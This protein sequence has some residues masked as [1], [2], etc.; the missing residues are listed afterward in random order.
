MPLGKKLYFTKELDKNSDLCRMFR[1][2]FNFNFNV[3]SP[4]LDY[5]MVCIF[6]VKCCRHYIYIRLSVSTISHSIGTL[7]MT[8][9][10]DLYELHDTLIYTQTIEMFP[11]ICSTIVFA[12]CQRTLCG[13]KF[14]TLDQICQSFEFIKPT[15][16]DRKSTDKSISSI[17]NIWFSSLRSKAPKYASNSELPKEFQFLSTKE[18][19]DQNFEFFSLNS[20]ARIVSVFYVCAQYD[21]TINWQ[22][23]RIATRHC[24]SLSSISP[25]SSLSQAAWPFDTFQRLLSSF[26]GYIAGSRCPPARTIQNIICIRVLSCRCAIFPRDY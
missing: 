5:P 14:I 19:I 26:Y 15:K 6:L 10:H 21:Q 1:R 4:S 16:I 3:F 22:R 11:T 24:I 25:S 13:W 18:E 9:L 8:L 2:N 17:V 7:T 12:R 23:V 20:H